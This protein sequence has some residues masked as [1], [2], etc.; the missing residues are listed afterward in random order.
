MEEKKTDTKLNA[1]DIIART[2]RR[3][4]KLQAYSPESTSIEGATNQEEQV[5]E[6]VQLPVTEAIKELPREEPRKRKSKAQVE[7]DYQS[8]FI[9][10]SAIAARSGKT[11]Y[12][13]KEHHERIIK[14]L[15]VIAKN[16]VSLFSYIY[17]V[18]EHHFTTYQ[19]D[20]T[21]LYDNNIEKI[22]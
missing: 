17:N 21:E 3:E 16:D 9:H 15:H 12:I 6:Q 13:C 2:G 8:L 19:E 14:I 20:I 5:E 22:F 7:A 10:E 18:L 1:Q 4:R 11:V